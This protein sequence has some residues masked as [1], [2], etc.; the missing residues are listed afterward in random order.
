[1]GYEV[2]IFSLL[3]FYLSGISA[4]DIKH[5]EISNFAPVIV[6]MASPFISSVPFTERLIGLFGLLI[7][8]TIVSILTNGFGMGDVKLSAAFG[9]TLG[10]LWGICSLTAGLIVSIIVGKISRQKSLPLAPFISGAGLAAVIIKEVLL[11]C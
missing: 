5:R 11:Q 8:L 7:P 6:I 10:A 4:Q 1:M 9:W 2:T 3:A